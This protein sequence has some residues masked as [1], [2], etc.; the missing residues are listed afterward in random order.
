LTYTIVWEPPAI[1]AA[2]RFLAEDSAGL[3]A[4]FATIDNLA[5]DPRPGTSLPFGSQDL[6]RIRVGRYRALYQVSDSDRTVVVT[7]LGRSG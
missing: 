4:L 1:D 3:R 2:S 6:R 5:T 7:H